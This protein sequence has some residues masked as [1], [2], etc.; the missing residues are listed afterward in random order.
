MRPGQLR[1]VRA[2]QS[3]RLASH[4]FRA[5]DV[6]LVLAVTVVL[7]VRAAPGSA[8]Q[9]PIALVAPFV[10]GLLVLNHVL[11]A[12]GVYRFDRSTSWYYH[13]AMVVG[14]TVFVGACTAGVADLLDSTGVAREAIRWWAP[15]A[16]LGLAV[17][18][19]L[20]WAQVRHWRKRH[21]LTP[22]IVLV[23]A[24]ARAEHL[25][26]EALARGDINVLGVF[27]DRLERSPM[28]VLGVPMLGNTDALLTHRVM[29]HVDLIVVTVD[30]S[31]TA[32]VREIMAKLSVLPNPI[33]M[34]VDQEDETA[35]IAAVAHLAD[36]PLA[37]LGR[38]TD[39]DRKAIA[40]RVQDLTV[41]IPMLVAV[42]P[43]LVVTAIAVKI[44]SRGPILFRQKR[45]GFHNEAIM[46]MKFRS[47]RHAAADAKAERQ[48]T[49][50]DDRVTRVGR[51]L[52][53]TSLDEL[54]QLFN[55]LHG[56]MSLVGP[57]P[58]AIGMKTGDTESS[59]LVADYA[60]RHRIKPGLTGWAAV[61]GSRGPLHLPADVKRRVALDVEYIERQ[62]L[63]LDLKIM[64]LTLPALLGDRSSIR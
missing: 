27:D 29:P 11:T 20:W 64:F 63:G 32:R 35:R 25:I 44:D 42:L 10:L 6:L 26:N 16:V 40:K 8:L 28:N 54:P 56:E 15:I 9:A 21:W 36:A 18:H 19:L 55:V 22:N 5:V 7:V 62:S 3:R 39:P 17:L 38:A 24:T 37:P 41:A 33:T 31:A 58:H 53:K 59:Q 13:L 49:A 45:H 46:V 52:R 12:I 14:I 1:S 50:N 57:R 23:G 61:H 47:M 60:H 30:P 34:V 4:A 51:F 43:V 2:R 48:V